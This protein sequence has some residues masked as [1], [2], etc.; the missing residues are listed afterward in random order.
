MG[1]WNG[2]GSPADIG[3]T[4]MQR[5]WPRHHVGHR[6]AFDETLSWAIQSTSLPSA[7]IDCYV[8]DPGGLRGTLLE[9]PFSVTTSVLQGFPMFVL[10]VWLS[11]RF[12]YFSSRSSTSNSSVALVGIT[13]PA[14]RA[15]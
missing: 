11:S 8:P 14:P 10:A 2:V 4:G 3:S 9:I 13:P 7:R 15:P 12:N 5:Q 1:C 6:P